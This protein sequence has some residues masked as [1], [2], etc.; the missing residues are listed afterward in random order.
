MSTSLPKDSTSDSRAEGA[1]SAPAPPQL[2]SFNLAIDGDNDERAAWMLEHEDWLRLIVGAAA[3]APPALEQVGRYS[4]REII[5]DATGWTTVPLSGPRR[6]GHNPSWVKAVDYDAALADVARL[7]TPHE[8]TC[9][10]NLS[11]GMKTTSSESAKQPNPSAATRQSRTPESVPTVAATNGDAPPAS[12]RGSS[13]LATEL[14]PASP[15][16]VEP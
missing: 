5:L 11:S 9:L 6:L 16:D 1:L 10:T 12:E 7:Q 13:K 15:K 4:T 8:G 3:P 2:K 14:A